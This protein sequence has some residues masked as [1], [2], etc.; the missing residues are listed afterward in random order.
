MFKKE[1]YYVKKKV[2]MINYNSL[3]KRKISYYVEKK[4]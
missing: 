4:L 3:S 1:H 2:T